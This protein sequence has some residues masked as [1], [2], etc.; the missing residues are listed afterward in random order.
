VRQHGFARSLIHKTANQHTCDAVRSQGAE[1]KNERGSPDSD[2]RGIASIGSPDVAGKL[3]RE[4]DYAS[5]PT[6]RTT[7]YRITRKRFGDWRVCRRRPARA[8]LRSSQGRARAW[9]YCTRSSV[10]N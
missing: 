4:T 9:R 8:P 6:G 1:D 2:R 10:T 7:I 3:S 5:P